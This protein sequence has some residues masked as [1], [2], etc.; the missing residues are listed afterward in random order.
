VL[1]C[2]A[3]GG[4][5]FGLAGNDPC[6]DARNGSFVG[7]QAA[8]AVTGHEGRSWREGILPVVPP[9]FGRNVSPKRPAHGEL[10]KPRGLAATAEIAGT[11]AGVRSNTQNSTI[12][13]LFRTEHLRS[14]NIL[15][16][17]PWSW[18]C[19]GEAALAVPRA[20]RR[21]TW[22]AGYRDAQEAQRLGSSLSRHG[23]A[24]AHAASEREHVHTPGC[25]AHRG[26]AAGQP[27]DVDV[28]GTLRVWITAVCC[29]PDLAHV[30]GVVST[31]RSASTA[32]SETPALRWQ[33]MTRRPAS[34]PTRQGARPRL[35]LHT[36]GT[37]WI[38]N[39]LLSP[40][41]NYA[42]GPGKGIVKARSGPRQ[43][44]R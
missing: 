40:E 36:P 23:G 1:A 12:F 15:R 29:G 6:G 18:F 8:C 4:Q 2:R 13:W 34:C 7:D 31:L 41:R 11:A 30:G 17:R 28:D 19:G 39:P 25:R 26:D 37:E 33:V 24:L 35:R 3:P 10:K 14:G 21:Q 22:I 9:Y 27:V 32:A 42:R 44:H 16:P 38:M 5:V 20:A 43:L